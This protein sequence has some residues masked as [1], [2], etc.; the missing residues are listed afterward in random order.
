MEAMILAAG[1]GT[2]LRPL[3]YKRPK[4]LIPFLNAPL[5]E[6]NLAY[7][8]DF[9][10]KRII[11]NTHHLGD[12]VAEFVQSWRKKER[13]EVQLQFES[14]ILGTGGGIARTRDFWTF[15]HFLVVNADILTDIDL[16]QVREFHLSHGGP[17]TLVLHDYPA[18]NQIEVDDQGRIQR[19]RTGSGRGL[20]FTGIHLLSREI[21]Q[22]LPPSGSYD[23]I[24]VYQRMIDQGLTVRAFISQGHYWRDLGTPQSYLAAHEDILLNQTSSIHLSALKIPIDPFVL[25][26]DVIPEEGIEI[27]GWAVIGKGCHLK[28]GCRIANSVLWENVVL[29]KGVSV[30]DS[31]VADGVCV[32]ADVHDRVLV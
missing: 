27:N 24:P 25:H 31:I 9:S 14:E 12:Q 1:E 22:H 15:Q 4:P 26:P 6:I 19:F 32:A 5:L 8:R 30:S 13:F 2:R 7:L 16:N 23:I 28:K 3:T 11:V 20:A 29:E 21:F 18:F 17:V 10:I